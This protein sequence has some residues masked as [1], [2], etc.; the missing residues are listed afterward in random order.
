M[1]TDILQRTFEQFRYLRL[2][3]PNRIAVEADFNPFH[4]V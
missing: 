4:V 2:Q 1:E 3:Q